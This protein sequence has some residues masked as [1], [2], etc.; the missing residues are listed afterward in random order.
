MKKIFKIILLIILFINISYIN[1][2][3][4]NEEV[5]KVRL[6]VTNADEDYQIYILLP[7]KY[8]MYA[9]NY[10]GLNIEYDKANTLIYNN[11]P[12]ISVDINDIQKDTYIDEEN[13]IEYVQILLD[14]LGGEEYYF[15]IIKEYT[16][17]DMLYRIKSTSRDNL[18]HIN[19]FSLEDNS[20]DMEYNYKENTITTDIHKDIKIKFDFEWWQIL[21]IVILTIFII[22]LYKRRNK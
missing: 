5:N 8:I 10:D 11:I 19:N 16:D 3:A 7:K 15:E 13:R 18:L 9:I 6:N 21:A 17:M 12:S 1:V 14:D 2:S 4:T 20:C 22:Y